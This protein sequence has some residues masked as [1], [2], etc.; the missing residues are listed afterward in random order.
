MNIA[1]LDIRKQFA[2]SIAAALNAG[3]QTGNAPYPMR[4]AG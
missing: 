4:L 2:R 3:T 1:E